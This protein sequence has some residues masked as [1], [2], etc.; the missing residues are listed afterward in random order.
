MKKLGDLE[1]VVMDIIWATPEPITVREVLGQVERTRP[2]AYT[3]VMT[4]MDNLHR[5]GF[6]LRE[7]DGR[8]YRYRPA[9]P[10]ADHAAELMS[11]LLAGSGDLSNTLLR[12]VDHMSPEELSS[13]KRALG[14]RTRGGHR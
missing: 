3:T 14:R 8:A 11:E 5:K 13:L 1:A 2:L 4:V 6:L 9:K 10:R 12:F 7:L